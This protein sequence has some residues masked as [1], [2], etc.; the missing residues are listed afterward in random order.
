M[1][2]TICALAT[3]Q[4]VG[5]I[6]VI[7]LS[8]P[9]SFEILGN[10]FKGKDLSKVASH[11]VH[12]G[13][14][15]YADGSMLDEVLVTVFRNPHSY[16]REDTAEISFHGSPFILQE[17]LRLLCASGARMANPGEFT[18]RAFLNGQLDLSQA[19]AVADIIAAE[20]QA[21][22]RL[23]VRQM[24]G[25]YSDQMKNLRTELVNFASLIELEL[26]FGEE[27]VE[28]ANRDDLK[29]TV[30][31]ILG[32]I[33]SL[34]ESFKYGNVLKNGIPTVIAGPPNAGKSTLLNALLK[35]ERAIVS[36]I[37]GTTR[38]TVEEEFTLQGVKFRL[39]D[40][41]GLRVTDDHVEAIG[42]ERAI[43]KIAQAT[44]LLYVFDLTDSSPE[45]VA[46]AVKPLVREGLQVVLVGSKVDLLPSSD[47]DG[48]ID[49]L[50]PIQLSMNIPMFIGIS[51]HTGHNLRLL[52]SEMVSLATANA[53]EGDSTVVSN[54]RHHVALSHAAISLQR[55]LDGL[56]DN[57]TGD[58]LAMD[59]RH[60]IRHLSE[61]VGDVDVE[62]LLENI[63]S[64]FCIGK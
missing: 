19:E 57:V 64:K 8:G 34:E 25:G 18:Q 53:H 54:A 62:D 52:E 42:V 7:R 12:F 36:P 23:A 43:E 27:D 10:Y 13:S 30:S 11:T 61:I 60:S 38:D 35:E 6:G 45:Q 1:S 5:A 4:G 29:T 59:I 28:F 17:A 49:Q 24:R 20:S 48:W 33:R 21:A 63:F 46:N 55:V 58:F 14:F 9:Q 2:D 50:K 40:T 32:L 16:T 3:P 41:A 51:A 37:A 56:S 39:I 47:F 44:L 15:R 26:D 31:R 22:H